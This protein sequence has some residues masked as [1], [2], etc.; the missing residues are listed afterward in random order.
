MTTKSSELNTLNRY[1]KS[2]FTAATATVSS[3]SITQRPISLTMPNKLPSPPYAASSYKTDQMIQ[4]DPAKGAIN[5][6]SIQGQIQPIMKFPRTKRRFVQTWY[7]KYHWLEYSI[8]L[9]RAF[10]YNCRLFA[11]RSGNTEYT[12]I[13]GGFQD[14]EHATVQFKKHESA[15]SHKAASL[16]LNARIHKDI[17]KTSI[18]QEIESLRRENVKNNREY[19]RGLISTILFLAKQNIAMRGHNENASSLNRGN[20][21]E[22][23]DLRCQEI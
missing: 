20:Y 19:M 23:Y 21:F 9:D 1:F 18:N 8:T 14:W 7:E 12:Y 3:P 11:T 2:R 13:T 10:C 22:L 6:N 16:S 5:L 17:D 4:T 15:S